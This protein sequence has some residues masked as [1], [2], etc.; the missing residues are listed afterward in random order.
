M[1]RLLTLL[2]LCSVTNLILA[3]SSVIGTLDFENPDAYVFQTAADSLWQVGT[4]SKTIFNN[5]FSPTHAAITD[6]LNMYP[7]NSDASLYVNVFGYGTQDFTI[8]FQH[9]YDTETGKDGGIVEVYD[10][11]NL[12]WVNITDALMGG[13]NYCVAGVY[14]PA[15]LEN[16]YT[17]NDTLADGTAAFSGSSTGWVESKIH[18]YCFAVFQDPNTE[19]GGWTD[20][21]NLRFRFVSDANETSQEGWMLDDITLTNSGGVCGGIDEYKIS[22]QL[23]VFPNPSKDKINIS[24]RNS[25]IH[26]LEIFSVTGNLLISEKNIQRN[27]YATSIGDFP[28]GIYLIRATDTEKNYHLQRLIV[29]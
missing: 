14:G 29:E 7:V 20:T 17:A 9:Q 6:T 19:R 18:F 5:A 1:K 25:M 11:C 10:Y 16:F 3:Q 27:Y 15:Y 22:D 4:P 12:V 2:C 26:S 24:I 28:P 8:S 13:T 21:V 23:T